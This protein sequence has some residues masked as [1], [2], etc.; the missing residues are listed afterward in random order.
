MHN[1]SF[2]IVRIT[3]S[4]ACFQ[5]LG[6]H[7]GMVRSAWWVEHKPLKVDLRCVLGE[8]GAPSAQTSFGMTEKPEHSAD[9]LATRM[10]QVGWALESNSQLYS[11]HFSKV[12]V[13][14]C[15]C[16]R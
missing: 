6:Q 2:S 3:H 7:V 14:V 12:C 10:C 5:I 8:N 4:I 16:V 15:V 9:S 11:H 1:I 13:C